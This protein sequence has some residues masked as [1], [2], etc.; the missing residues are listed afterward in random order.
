MGDF[1][2]ENNK[3]TKKVEI[4]EGEEDKPVKKFKKSRKH[5]GFRESECSR[6]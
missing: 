1:E 6:S 3:L 4:I 5:S 2:E